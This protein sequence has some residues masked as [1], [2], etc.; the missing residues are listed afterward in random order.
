MAFEVR[1]CIRC[2][3]REVHLRLSAA[4]EWKMRYFGASAPFLGGDICPDC[5]ILLAKMV[6][7]EFKH[8][9]DKP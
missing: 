1:I 5:F 8:L 9:E 3:A 2:G 7:A 4:E 6:N